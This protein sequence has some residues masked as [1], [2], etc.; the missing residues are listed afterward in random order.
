MADD[1]SKMDSP[2]R[3][4]DVHEQYEVE[5]WSHKWNVSPD[6]L[7]EAVSRAGPMVK[8]VARELGKSAC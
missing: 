1:K 5:Y 7:R 8:D 3:R 4:I 6:R 2:D